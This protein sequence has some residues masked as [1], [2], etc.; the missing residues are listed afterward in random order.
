MLIGCL[1][2]V[3][4]SVGVLPKDVGSVAWRHPLHCRDA[5]LR[6]SPVALVTTW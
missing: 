1:F 6:L 2:G 4:S 3:L 5:G